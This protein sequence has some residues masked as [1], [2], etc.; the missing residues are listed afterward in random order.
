MRKEDMTQK[1]NARP[2]SKE[3]KTEGMYEDRSCEQIHDDRNKMVEGPQAQR[4]QHT[5]TVR[6]VSSTTK[7]IV[8]ETKI[9]PLGHILKKTEETNFWEKV[10]KYCD[11]EKV[12][13]F[14]EVVGRYWPK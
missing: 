1:G 2:S 12:I 4:V 5:K 13:R 9:I 11:P 10:K 3:E 8:D 6:T 7:T 14:I